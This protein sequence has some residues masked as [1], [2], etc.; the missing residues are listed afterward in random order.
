MPRLRLQR[1]SLEY[2]TF[3]LGPQSALF[4]PL[5][6]G[7]FD[8]ALSLLVLRRSGLYSRHSCRG[9]VN[10]LFL[11]LLRGFRTGLLWARAAGTPEYPGGNRVVVISLL[12]VL[13]TKG[14]MQPVVMAPKNLST[15]H[16]KLQKTKQKAKAN[17]DH[18]RTEQNHTP[19][20]KKDPRKT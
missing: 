5:L 17:R 6:Q 16:Y 10:A 9:E 8:I 3:G 20:E 13:G 7:S 19:K 11:A 18:R 14:R 15:K 12:F 4:G 2:H 1:V